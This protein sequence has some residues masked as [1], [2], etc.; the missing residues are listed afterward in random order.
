MQTYLR[1]KAKAG[2]LRQPSQ[3]YHMAMIMLSAL[4]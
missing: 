3:T 4:C 1:R 2:S